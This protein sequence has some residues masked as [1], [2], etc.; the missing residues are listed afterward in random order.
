MRGIL[1]Y[2]TAEGK[3]IYLEIICAKV[4][5]VNMNIYNPRD[6]VFHGR[7]VKQVKRFK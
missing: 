3:K 6:Q 2:L 1:D 5:I 4:E 7:M